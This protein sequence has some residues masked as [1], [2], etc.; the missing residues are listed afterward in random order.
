VCLRLDSSGNDT[1]VV[2]ISPFVGVVRQPRRWY[3]ATDVNKKADGAVAR[4]EIRMS[5]WGWKFRKRRR[6]A[7]WWMASAI[8][9]RRHGVKHASATI[10]AWKDLTLEQKTAIE[11]EVYRA[12][13]PMFNGRFTEADQAIGPTF[14][15][16]AVA[17]ASERVD[18][19]QTMS[20]EEL[21]KLTRNG[22][23]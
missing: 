23:F 8:T 14:K 11:V 4:A 2:R 15:A 13:N 19:P 5:M 7:S 20:D 16:N 22:P 9:R 10:P 18:P 1:R 3:A 21:R 17:P 6:P 12:L